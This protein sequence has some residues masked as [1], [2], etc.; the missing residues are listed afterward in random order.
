MEKPLVSVICCFYRENPAW[1]RQSVESI[2]SQTYRHFEFI[3]I[4]DDPE[5]GP[6]VD[7]L[8]KYASADPR[9]LL[10]VNGQ[11]IGITR[12][13]NKGLQI[14]GGEF[15]ARMD[16][17]DIALPDRLEKQVSYLA[18][19]TETSICA[20]DV[21]TI[22]SRGRIIRRH[23]YRGLDNQ[24]YLFCRNIYAHPSIMFRKDILRYRTPL[25]N[26]VF[27]Y[28]QDYELWTFLLLKGC[29]FHMLEETLLLYR[30]SERQIS[31]GH[32][33]EQ[34]GFFKKAH[35]VLVTDW[36][37]KK[38][39]IDVTDDCSPEIMLLKASDAYRVNSGKD[40]E[41]LEIVIY[42]LYFTLATYDR[43]YVWRYFTDRNRIAFKVDILLTWRLIASRK[44]RCDRSGFLP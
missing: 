12:S 20:T 23:K 42:I 14:A 39:I 30:K 10:I 8:K 26:E 4:C 33:K 27:R 7:L 15:I 32:K 5:N 40:R 9:I 21:N 3:M 1:V 37:A 44:T 34:R 2:L 35:K 18:A 22:N 28:A 25:Y 16:A 13:L 19:H 29:R 6:L 11:N 31:S 43:R 24:K 41:Y 17:D 36:L 38:G